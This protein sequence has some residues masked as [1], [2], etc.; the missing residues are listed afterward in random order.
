MDQ[1]F[2]SQGAI[3]K[4]STASPGGYYVWNFGG[5][6]FPV[7]AKTKATARRSCSLGEG[8]KETIEH[9]RRQQRLALDWVKV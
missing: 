4:N 3:R 1:P 6:A 5:G 8:D 7:A 2:P 9:L